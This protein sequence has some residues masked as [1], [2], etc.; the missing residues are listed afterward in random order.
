MEPMYLTTVLLKR[1]YWHGNLPL[2]TTSCPFQSTFEIH[3][4]GILESSVLYDRN[5]VSECLIKTWIKLINWNIHF[6]G[7]TC[8][9]MLS[10]RK[11]KMHK[12]KLTQDVPHQENLPVLVLQV[13]WHEPQ[14]LVQALEIAPN[15]VV[16]SE[17]ECSMKNWARKTL[18][19]SFDIFLKQKHL[20]KQPNL[21]SIWGFPFP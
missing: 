14:S 18:Y 13:G 19:N 4:S 10:F 17:E 11:S 5:L 16:L 2:N 21:N 9:S 20:M 3:G 8:L 1:C 15:P 12:T 6:P 7:M